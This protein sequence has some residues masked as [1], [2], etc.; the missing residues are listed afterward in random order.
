MATGVGE[1]CATTGLMVTAGGALLLSSDTPEEDI[2]AATLSP[3][4]VAPKL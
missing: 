3:L 2:S 4:G 1:G